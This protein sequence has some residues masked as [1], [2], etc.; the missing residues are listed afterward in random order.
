MKMKKE[1]Y[2]NE[3][4]IFRAY[5]NKYNITSKDFTLILKTF[6]FI[7]VHNM[8][9]KYKIYKLPYGL[10]H[11]GIYKRN[12]IGRGCFDWKLF[13][14]EGIKHWKK[15]LHTHGLAATCAWDRR[16]PK[17]RHYFEFGM[18]KFKFARDSA[19]E[20]GRYINNNNIIHNYYD[21]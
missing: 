1:D 18:F 12:T 7:M 2:V 9:Y 3:L 14:T 21:Y 13:H 17:V 8:I 6:F 16:Y 10:G 20:L 15:N 4:E 11:M 19:R 5:P